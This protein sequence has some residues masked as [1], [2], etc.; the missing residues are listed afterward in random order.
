MLKFCYYESVKMA[1]GV[2]FPLFYVLF[3]YVIMLSRVC[4]MAVANIY[5]Y[6]SP[7]SVVY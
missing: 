5:M 4:R 3:R 6:Y 2:I 7:I 1:F